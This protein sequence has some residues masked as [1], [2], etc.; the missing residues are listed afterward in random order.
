MAELSEPAGESCELQ[1]A[2][3]VLYSRLIKCRENGSILTRG[4]AFVI[5]DLLPPLLTHPFSRSMKLKD[6]TKKKLML[7]WIS[8]VCRWVFSLFFFFSV[9]SNTFKHFHF[10]FQGAQ[11]QG[12]HFKFDTE[13]TR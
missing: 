7:D 5:K 4:K 10:K 8:A 3:L 11:F 12:A 1:K 9:F 6:K 13:C 2:T